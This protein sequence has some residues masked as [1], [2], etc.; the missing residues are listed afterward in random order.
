MAERLNLTVE[1]DVGEMLTQLAGGER[2]RSAYLSDLVKGIH[3]SEQEAQVSDL[4]ELKMAFAGL[5][6]KSKMIEWRL[7]RLE[8]QLAAVINEIT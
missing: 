7:Q 4:E 2:K 5:V 1:P 3:E 6:G 8:N